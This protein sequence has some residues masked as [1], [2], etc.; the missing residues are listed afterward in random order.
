MAIY[1]GC[2]IIGPSGSGKTT[3]C[4]GLSQYYSAVKRKYVVINLDPAN[5]QLSYDV[6]TICSF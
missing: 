3:L 6:N 4:N 2:V 1:Y 5:E